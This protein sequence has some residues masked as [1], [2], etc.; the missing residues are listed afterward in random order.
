MEFSGYIFV[1]TPWSKHIKISMRAAFLLLSASTS[2]NSDELTLRQSSSFAAALPP[3][4]A[5]RT[6]RHLWCFLVLAK[7]LYAQLPLRE[8]HPAGSVHLSDP[9]LLPSMQLHQQKQSIGHQRASQSRRLCRP[10]MCQPSNTMVTWF[11]W[12]FRLLHQWWWAHPQN[13]RLAVCF[14]HS[15]MRRHIRQQLYIV[16]CSCAAVSCIFQSN[17]YA[18]LFN[19]LNT[20]LM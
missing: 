11:T 19:H 5:S 12:S 1:A 14:V 13:L 4:H 2:S 3:R 8:L 20:L 10:S 6:G 18:T 7:D 15:F 17:Y 9:Q 16:P